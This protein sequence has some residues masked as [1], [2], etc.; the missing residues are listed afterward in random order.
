MAIMTRAKFHFNRLLLTLIFGIWAS[1]LKPPGPGERPGLIGL[2]G[3]Y[4][5]VNELDINSFIKYPRSVPNRL[6]DSKKPP[7]KLS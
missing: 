2:T 7:G 6:T 3:I 5:N 1:E 4:A